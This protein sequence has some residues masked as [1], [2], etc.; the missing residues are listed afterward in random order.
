MLQFC[1]LDDGHD[2]ATLARSQ[3]AAEGVIGL[4]DRVAALARSALRTP[5]VRSVVAGYEHWRE[6]FVAATV[7]ARVL[8][9]YVDLLVRTPGG[10]VIVDYKTDQ[11]SGASQTAERLERYRLQLAAYGAALES[12]IGEPISGGLLVRCV[13]D[14]DADQ[15]AV[16][17]WVDAMRRGPSARQLILVGRAVAADPHRTV[18]R[19]RRHRRAAELEHALAGEHDRT[20]RRNTRTTRAANAIAAGTAIVARTSRRSSNSRLI[21]PES[22]SVPST[23]NVRTGSS[24]MGQSIE[25]S[26]T[27]TTS[28]PPKSGSGGRTDR[29]QRAVLRVESGTDEVLLADV[30]ESIVVAEP[31]ID[32]SVDRPVGRRPGPQLVD[33]ES[34]HLSDVVL[35]DR[36]TD[37]RERGHAGFGAAVRDHDQARRP[38]DRAGARQ[39]RGGRWRRRG[40]TFVGWCRRGATLVEERVRWRDGGRQRS[41]A[42]PSQMTASAPIQG[43]S[44]RRFT[45]RG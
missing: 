20:V 3:C 42:V 25:L 18:I 41:A 13:A 33:L 12:A 9:G 8:E 44:H 45:Q 1:D 24:T 38:V 16:E 23:I 17:R 11:W 22:T 31:D 34:D 43:A 29:R 15:I 19:H 21:T 27:P 28:L 2:I 36:R 6:L 14:G 10:L 37:E 7:G 5:I 30:E 4:E 32:Q 39:R 40:A 26:S 35:A